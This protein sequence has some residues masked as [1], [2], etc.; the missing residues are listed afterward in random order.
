M[1]AREGILLRGAG[2]Q[3]ATPFRRAV[4]EPA[5]PEQ[6]QQVVERRSTIRRASDLPVVGGGQHLRL[7][8]V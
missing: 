8:D 2:A 3:Q 4:R 6:P 7:G 5:A 1:T